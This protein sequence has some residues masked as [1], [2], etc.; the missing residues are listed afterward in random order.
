[1][2]APT[3]REGRFRYI[4][5]Y[6]FGAESAS[7]A[8]MTQQFPLSCPGMPG[9]ITRP[10]VVGRRAGALS[11]LLMEAPSSAVLLTFD[12]DVCAAAP[13]CASNTASD[14]NHGAEDPRRLGHAGQLPRSDFLIGNPRSQAPP[15]WPAWPV[16]PHSGTS[17]GLS[18]VDHEA[19]P[20]PPRTVEGTPDDGPARHPQASSSAPI[21]RT[22]I[23]LHTGLTSTVRTHPG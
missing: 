1:M 17:W 4:S 19:N 22:P 10:G 18:F 20:P 23:G 6:L 16:Y 15:A 12:I 21:V 13:F 9:L 14:R 11:T 5:T 8:R 2:V 3:D 7:S